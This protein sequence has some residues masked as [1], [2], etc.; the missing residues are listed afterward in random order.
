F[1]GAGADEQWT[2]GVVKNY[3]RCTV[4]RQRGSPGNA[5]RF[6][7]FIGSGYVDA[8]SKKG[9]QLVHLMHVASASVEILVGEELI[10]TVRGKAHDA[11]QAKTGQAVVGETQRRSAGALQVERPSG[12]DGLENAEMGFSC[13]ERIGGAE[14]A[15]V[16]LEVGIEF[17]AVA[18]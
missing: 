7:H 9:R 13:R 3:S 8:S 15:V 5:V 11:A 4:H 12:T 14:P 2:E 10:H 6:S 17:N 16:P 18:R 1:A